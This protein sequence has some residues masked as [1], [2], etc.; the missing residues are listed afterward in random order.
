[1]ISNVEVAAYLNLQNEA[2]KDEN[3]AECCF[4]HSEQYDLTN[5]FMNV[6]EQID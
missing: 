2:A 1:M 6:G 4:F 5:V 3:V